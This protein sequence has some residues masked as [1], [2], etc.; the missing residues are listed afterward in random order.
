MR[1]SPGKANDSHYRARED[2][3]ARATCDSLSGQ[4]LRR[5]DPLHSHASP[6]SIVPADD[7]D[8]SGT[9]MFNVT[10]PSPQHGI[11][12]VR[13]SPCRCLRHL[14]RRAL[15]RVLHACR[16]RGHPPRDGAGPSN[17]AA[18][19][20][21][22][23]RPPAGH[24]HR[25]PV[26][27]RRPPRALASRHRPRRGQLPSAPR[28]RR[29]RPAQ[30]PPAARP[31]LHPGVLRR[32]P[33]ARAV[34]LVAARPVHGR[35]RPDRGEG[36]RGDHDQAQAALPEDRPRRLAAER[37]EGVAA[38]DRRDGEALLGRAADRHLLGDRQRDRHRRERR[39]P[40]PDPGRRPTTPSSTR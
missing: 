31:R 34:R 20:A 1:E 9:S 32:L 36:R 24:R 17:A 11:P 38:G 15:C 28:P 2:G 3:T 22:I 27:G 7:T 4:S 39:L 14:S 40:V 10:V 18:V 6:G 8:D 16:G 25:G 13:S 33:R 23:R 5:L 37:R 35:A 30:A 29:G 26:Q 19:V 21:P 12:A